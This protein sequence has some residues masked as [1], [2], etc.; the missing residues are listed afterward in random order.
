MEIEKITGTFFIK[1]GISCENAED[2][3]KTVKA[4]HTFIRHYKEISPVLLTIVK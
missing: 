3:E 4:L 1:E 2:K